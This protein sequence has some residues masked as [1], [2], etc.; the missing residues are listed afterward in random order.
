MTDTATSTPHVGTVLDGRYELVRHIARGGM[1][2][3]F[4]ATDQ[5]L[6]R[7]VAVKVFRAASPADRA[8]FDAEV[9]VLAGLAHE[10]LVRVFDAGPHGDDAYVVLELIDGP[11]L[12][13]VFEQ[14]G[15]LPSED[16]ARLGAEVADALAYIHD[17][18]VVHRDVTPAN[19]LCDEGGLPRLVD[20]GIARLLD[21]PRL[22][23]T[24][25]TVGTPCTWPRSSWR[26]GPSR[27]PPTSTPS[28]SCSWRRSTGRRAFEGTVQETLMA[29]LA[30]GPDAPGACPSR[31]A[32]C[33]VR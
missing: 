27:R 18:G 1:G 25:M 23:T 24:S 10:G 20:F 2:D 19:V 8:R 29:R 17:H 21:S 9:R 3:V 22:T 6:R 26:A 7:S 12:S 13:E 11:P 15:P 30:S 28:A 4:E 31:G 5:V 32:S 14:R 16:A 33:S